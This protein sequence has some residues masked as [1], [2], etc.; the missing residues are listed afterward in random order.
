MTNPDSAEI[1]DELPDYNPYYIVYNPSTTNLMEKIGIDGFSMSDVITF[2]TGR[3]PDLCDEKSY[4]KYLTFDNAVQRKGML[5]QLAIECYG[6]YYIANQICR[7]D[8]TARVILADD[9]RRTMSQII[10]REHKKPLAV[11]ITTISSSFPTA[12]A[13]AR[14][15]MPE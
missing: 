15:M 11:F 2:L 13:A 12:C 1:T 10:S 6:Q 4:H 7:A 3:N 9:K 8:A 14:P 5:E